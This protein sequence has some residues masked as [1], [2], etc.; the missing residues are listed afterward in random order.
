MSAS[1]APSADE[2]FLR[3][4]D[5]KPIFVPPPSTFSFAAAVQR[6]SSL[7]LSG[8]G[9]NLKTKPPQFDYIGKVGTSVDL[10]TAVTAAR[11]VGLNL[12]VTAREHLGSLDVVVAVIETRVMVNS[13]SGFTDQSTV[14]NGCTDLFVEVFGDAGKGARIAIGVSELPFDM[15]VEI[16]SVLALE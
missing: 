6:G 9:P 2:K 10:T 12:L 11:L 7:Y 4:P 15:S 14:A 8:H 5:E 16:S 1:S 13:A 3:L